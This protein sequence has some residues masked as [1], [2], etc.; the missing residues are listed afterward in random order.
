M[1][2]APKEKQITREIPG[3]RDEVKILYNP[4]T[5]SIQRVHKI[6]IKLKL[7]MQSLVI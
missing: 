5:V 4:K 7:K 3:N 1:P 6:C 2:F